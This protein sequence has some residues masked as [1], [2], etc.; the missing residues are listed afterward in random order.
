MVVAISENRMRDLADKYDKLYNSVPLDA[1]VME[2]VSGHI[3]ATS[4]IMMKT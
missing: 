3:K 1:E 4:N 2:Q